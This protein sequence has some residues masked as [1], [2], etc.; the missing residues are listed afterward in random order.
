MRFL[1]AGFA[2]EQVRLAGQ[3]VFAVSGGDKI[4]ACKLSFLGHDYRVGSHIGDQTGGDANA[5][6]HTFVKLLGDAHGVAGGKFQQVIGRLLQCT[7]RE[8][9]WRIAGFRGEFH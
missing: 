1:C 4:T 7:G 8:R 5:D 9:R 3:I 6:I 2:F